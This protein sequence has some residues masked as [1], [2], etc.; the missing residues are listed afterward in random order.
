MLS[1]AAAVAALSLTQAEPAH[2]KQARTLVDQLAREEFKSVGGPFNE[3]MQKVMPPEKLAFTWKKVLDL[4]GAFKS[5]GAV[6]SRHDGGY[7]IVTL[8]LQFERGAF[9]VNVVFDTQGKITGLLFKPQTDAT[10]EPLA[11]R[12]V[13]TLV[14]EK[15]DVIVSGF[16]ATMTEKM[17]APKLSEVWKGVAG[18]AGKLVAVNRVKVDADPK[19]QIALVGC[20]FEKGDLTVKVVFDAQKKVAGLFFLD[21]DVTAPWSPP[22]YAAPDK[23]HERDVKVGVKN[24]AGHVTLPNG[25]GPFPGLVLVHGSGPNDEDESIGP[26]KVFKDLALGLASRGVAVLRYTKRTKAVPDTGPS[27]REEAV[28]DALAGIDVLKAQPEVDPKRVFVLGHSLGGYLMPWVARDRPDV[29]GVVMLAGS[30][31]GMLELVVEQMTYFASLNP[32][33]EATK[34]I[35]EAKAWKARSEAKD[36]KDDEVIYGAPGVYWK[37]YRGYQPV[38]VA[39]KLKTP[40]LV[41]QGERDYQVQFKTDFAAFEKALKGHKNATLKSYPKLNHL[42]L[43]GEGPSTPAEYEKPGHVDET[44]VNDIAAWVTANSKPRAP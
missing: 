13:D 15:F 32:S 28:D 20:H 5:V 3:K 29:A 34:K 27:I 30:A 25:A 35:E 12:F 6:T 1:L 4:V 17:P 37:S 14:A 16:D 22:P 39:A 23:L 10:I 21:G 44:A 19:Y 41:L 7:D 2:E 36:L 18:K 38:E 26:N 8:A 24:L 42:F 40:M 43:A 31:R 9:D 11:R 33:P